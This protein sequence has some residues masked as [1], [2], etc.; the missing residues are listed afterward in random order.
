MLL[1]NFWNDRFFRPVVS[2]TLLAVASA[3]NLNAQSPER[4]VGLINHDAAVYNQASGKVYVVD[5]AHNSVSIIPPSGAAVAVSGTLP[6]HPTAAPEH[7]QALRS[8]HLRNGVIDVDRV[9]RFWNAPRM[10][11]RPGLK[12]IDL[13]E[14]ALDGKVRALWIL[15]TNPAV[16]MPRAARASVQ[17]FHHRSDLQPVEE[18]AH[19]RA[20][21]AVRQLGAAAR[22]RQPHLDVRVGEDLVPVVRGGHGTRRAQDA[23]LGVAVEFERAEEARRDA[24]LEPFQPGPEAVRQGALRAQAVAAML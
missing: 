7:V 9:R 24:V 18:R 5:A 17:P 3:L 12:A 6:V 10:A 1:R 23:R 13:F 15:N 2:F 14:A 8:I 11:G 22:G 19:G 4:E 20:G 21:E 16:S